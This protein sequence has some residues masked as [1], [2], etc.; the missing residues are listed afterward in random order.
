MRK[1]GGEQFTHKLHV[2]QNLHQIVNMT[3]Y[4][5]YVARVRKLVKHILRKHHKFLLSSKE[6]CRMD[7]DEFEMQ[8]P[9][10]YIYPHEF[11]GLGQNEMS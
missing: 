11:E 2:S 10:I 7:F 4:L 5:L 3:G 9:I 6:M 8:K 1:S